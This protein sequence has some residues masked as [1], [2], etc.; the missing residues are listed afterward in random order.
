MSK[1][2]KDAMRHRFLLKELIIKGIRLKYRRSYLGIV[3][4]LIEPLMNTIVL[5]IVF[6][7]LFNRGRDF[8]LYIILSARLN[9]SDKLESSFCKTAIPTDAEY[10]S[11]GS[12]S[13]PK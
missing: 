7:T 11:Q 9:T 5:V 4:S 6:G 8:S 2:I 1:Y 13:L 10:L 12:F 3:W